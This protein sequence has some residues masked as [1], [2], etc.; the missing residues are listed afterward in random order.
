[1]SMQPDAGVMGSSWHV[2]GCVASPGRLQVPPPAQPS[3]HAPP[4]H[5]VVSLHVAPW[6]L[7]PRHTLHGLP[8]SDPPMQRRPPQMPGAPPLDGQSALVEH[9]SCARSL[10]ESQRHRWLV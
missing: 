7:P 9:A 4:G 1:M 6:L 10:H 5:C 3:E 8:S 2:V